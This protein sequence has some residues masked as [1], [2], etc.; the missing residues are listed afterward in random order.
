MKYYNKFYQFMRGRYGVDSLYRFLF[1]LYFFLVIVN[2]FVSSRIIG[3]I[4]LFLFFFSLYRVFSKDIL[5]RKR[6]EEYYLRVKRTVIDFFS[7]NR[8]YYIYRKCFNCKTKLRLPLPSK[9]GF[10]RVVCPVCKKR[11]RIFTL[12]KERVQVIR[13][14]VKND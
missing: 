2:I 1:Y 7:G 4:S 9:R 8:G 12:R 3:G 14:K 5:K 6:E 13:K 11:I 10:Q